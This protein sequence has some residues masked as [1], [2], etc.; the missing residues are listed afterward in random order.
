MGSVVEIINPIDSF[1]L[2]FW[3]GERTDVRW[4]LQIVC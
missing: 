2:G 1:N 3:S 4:R